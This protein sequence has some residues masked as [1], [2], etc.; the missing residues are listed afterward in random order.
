MAE[1]W[2]AL[3]A[4]RT[5]PAAWVAWVAVAWVAAAWVA[6]VVPAICR[7]ISAVVDFPAVIADPAAPVVIADPAAPVDLE[8]ADLERAASIRMAGWAVD[9]ADRGLE[10]ST[11][12]TAV[13]SADRAES[14]ATIVS[15][16]PI[17][18]I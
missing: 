8:R 17:A 3:E 16:R 11:R 7:A 1:A 9:R 2:V 6:W 4:A 14:V 5:D 13:D 12:V 18:V 15:Q 10:D